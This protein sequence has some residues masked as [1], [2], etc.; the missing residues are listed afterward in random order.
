MGNLTVIP[1]PGLPMV[2]PGDDLVAIV[3]EAMAQA[4]LSFGFVSIPAD[5]P[6]VIAGRIVRIRSAAPEELAFSERILARW[7]GLSLTT[8]LTRI[9]SLTG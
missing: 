3:N 7:T 1:I 9:S 2:Q 6:D 4:D 8:G 5:V